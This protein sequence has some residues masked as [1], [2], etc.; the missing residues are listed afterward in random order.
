MI[1]VWAGST[2]IVTD[3]SSPTES[4]S[5]RFSSRNENG[6]TLI[7]VLV[8]III[9][10]I[11]A[12]IA[13][14]IF[15]NQQRAARDSATTQ[16]VR[17]LA[18]NVETALAS[19]PEANKFTIKRVSPTSA[20]ITVASD[21]KTSTPITFSKN[22]GTTLY[23]QPKSGEP[24][25]YV[26]RAYNRHGREYRGGWQAPVKYLAYDSSAGGITVLSTHAD[27]DASVVLS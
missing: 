24:G 25:E 6:F 15:L 11:L 7:E 13:I 26:I 8:V 23:I 1:R 22:D 17:N 14:P 12:A 4:K 20:T 21:T 10:G 3:H 16:D 27:E 9:I 5:M 18:T 19:V 2:R